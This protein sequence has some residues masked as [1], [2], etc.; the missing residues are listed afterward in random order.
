MKVWVPI[1]LPEGC[2]VGMVSA[3]FDD[4]SKGHVWLDPC[5]SPTV[6]HPWEHERPEPQ[7][8]RWEY[9][10]VS[11]A[12]L[13]DGRLVPAAGETGCNELGSDGWECFHVNAGAV[14]F[15]RRLP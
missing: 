2:R 11:G 12:D 15:K 7:R 5:D 14:W 9:R 8:E 13:G 1:D 6:N 3:I 10:I 4:T